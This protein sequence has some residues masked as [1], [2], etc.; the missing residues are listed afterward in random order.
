MSCATGYASAKQRAYHHLKSTGAILNTISSS[1]GASPSRTNGQHK[2]SY[3]HHLLERRY[4]DDGTFCLPI[5]ANQD[6]QL[7]DRVCTSATASSRACS[8]KVGT[9]CSILF[10]RSASTWL[11]SVIRGWPTTSST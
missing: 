10:G 2:H 7:R 1:A 4:N 9:G 5:E 3:Q 8:A 11:S 6:P